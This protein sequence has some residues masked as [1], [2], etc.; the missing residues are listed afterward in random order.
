MSENEIP[1]DIAGMPFET[2]VAELE[3]LV[4]AMENGGQTL[5]DLMAAFERGRF[6]A[7]HCRNQLSSLER[8]VAVL[9]ADDGKQGQ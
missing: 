8:K 9:A 7:E 4:A 3:K 5:N 1:S 6:L 2:A